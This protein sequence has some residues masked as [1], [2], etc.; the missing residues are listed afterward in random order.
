MATGAGKAQGSQLKRN[1]TLIA[2]CINIDGSGAKADMQDATN[3]DSTGGYREYVPTLLD[4]GE[5]SVNCNHLGSAGTTQTDLQ[6]DFDNQALQ[7]WT[8]DLP[9][10]LGGTYSFN[11]YVT[12]VDFKLAHDKLAEF[13]FK[14]K[15]TGPRTFA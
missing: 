14:L 4:A 6:S 15:I 13:S 8:I 10:A 9:P 1:G 2:E 5:I 7:S 3:M 12:A 11:A